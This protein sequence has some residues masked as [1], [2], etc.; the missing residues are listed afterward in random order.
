[1]YK[2]VSPGAI[3]VRPRDLNDAIAGA[4]QAGFAGLEFTRA[5]S[6]T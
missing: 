4:Q 1:M 6:L 2:A 5:K 3:G